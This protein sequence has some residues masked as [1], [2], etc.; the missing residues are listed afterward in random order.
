M[1]AISILQPWAT[2]IAI[3]AKKIEARSWST[4]YRGPIAIHASKKFSRS[5]QMICNREPFF[6]AIMSGMK[7]ASL[8]PDWPPLGA[9]IA[10]AELVECIPTYGANWHI[11]D[12]LRTPDEPERS[13]GDYSSGRYGWLLKNVRTL[14]TPVPAKGRLG[15]WEWEPK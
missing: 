10:T 13:F 11:S 9:I 1:K 6:A 4:S 2:L 15:L 14:E 7:S 12:C 8:S 3:G 5:Q